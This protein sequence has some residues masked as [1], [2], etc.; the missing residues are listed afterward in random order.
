MFNHPHTGVEDL[1]RH[2]ILVAHFLDSCRR[3]LSARACSQVHVVLANRQPQAWGL[4][5]SAA[6]VGM[7]CVA[8]VPWFDESWPGYVRRRHQGGSFARTRPDGNACVGLV[9]VESQRGVGL[10]AVVCCRSP[11]CL[12][13][14]IA[15]CPVPT[16][17]AM[18][19]QPALCLCLFDHR[20]RAVLS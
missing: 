16:C 20:M 4:L 5:E 1:I 14:L 18:S 15:T 10:S 7:C 17:T 9:A 13:A 11:A 3:V 8:R 6:R 12:L 19:P 2:R